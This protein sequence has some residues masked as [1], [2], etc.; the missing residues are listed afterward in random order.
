MK[1][2]RTND[3]AQS[4]LGRRYL[5]EHLGVMFD[6]S[7]YPEESSSAEASL[8]PSHDLEP[9]E[10]LAL[11]QLAFKQTVPFEDEYIE[12]SILQLE[13]GQPVPEYS[14]FLDH[15]ETVELMSLD[16]FFPDILEVPD[17][18][19]INQ[20]CPGTTDAPATMETDEQFFDRPEVRGIVNIDNFSDISETLL[21]IQV[22][23]EEP[24]EVSNHLPLSP[25]PPSPASSASS[26]IQVAPL[27]PE[28]GDAVY[29]VESIIQ[30]WGPKD[31]REYLIRWAGWSSEFDSWE[32]AGN[33]SAKLIAD[34]ERSS[35]RHRN[36]RRPGRGKMRKRRK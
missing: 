12:P 8:S 14:T 10:E 22:K 3:T 29:L 28:F 23:V 13:V 36:R 16:E 20:Y 26:C 11:H 21:C 25:A 30:G 15:A 1:A 33:V 27:S 35:L 6:S 4:A 24:E 2:A 5:R 9:F 19:D 34:F 18:I 17:S 31:H 7:N 32:P